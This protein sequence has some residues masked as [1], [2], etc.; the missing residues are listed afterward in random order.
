VSRRPARLPALLLAAWLASTLVWWAFA[1]APL[2]A[3]PPAW[4][5]AARVACFGPME[6]GLPGPAGW[7][8][9]VLAPLSFL[10]GIAVLWGVELP[11]AL[12]HAVRR[13]WGR[14]LL[15]LL[16]LVTMVEGVWVGQR[17]QAARA[18]TAW[19]PDALGDGELPDAYPRQAVPAPAFT[20]VDQHGAEVSLAGLRGRPVV[21]TFV[22]AHCQTMC[23]F[24]VATLRRAAPEGT[25]V[26]LVTLDPWRDTPSRL[27]GIARQWAL[28]PGFHVLSA[29]TGGDVLRVAEAYG[30]GFQRDQRTG[31]IVHPGLVFLVDAEGR[32]GYT[33]HNP[34]AA[35]VS[36]GLRRLGR[37][38][39]LAR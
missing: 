5:T 16:A 31:D 7:M 14:G 15:A 28:P 23:P 6:T 20:L 27:P 22:F 35:W 17:V 3:A 21:L 39:V 2:P 18:V 38:H 10:A 30:V 9:L 36:E 11:A 13:P 8:M 12:A 33:F 1:F 24:V 34:P 37:A 26:L 29:R 32:L 4:L 19:S 25:A